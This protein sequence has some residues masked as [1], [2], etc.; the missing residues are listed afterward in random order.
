MNPLFLLPLL[1]VAWE[2]LVQAGEIASRRETYWAAVKAALVCN[3]PLLIVGG[4]CP[5]RSWLARLLR[6]RGHGTGDVCIDIAPSACGNGVKADVRNI[7]YPDGYFGAAAVFH[8]LEHLPS[9]EDVKMAMDELERVADAVYLCCP[10]KWSILGHIHPGH[11]VWV[12]V[13]DGQVYV[14]ERGQR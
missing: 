1:P 2:T 13:E 10:S 8:V 6:P 11:K 9:A 5:G 3:K 12:E 14:E 7:P 4:P